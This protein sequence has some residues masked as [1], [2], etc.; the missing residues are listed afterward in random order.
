MPHAIMKLDN[1]VFFVEYSGDVYD[2]LLIEGIYL[3]NSQV[4]LVEYMSDAILSKAQ[5]E[6]YQDYF[7]LLACK[8]EYLREM[9]LEMREAARSD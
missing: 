6:V 4:N 7:D 2:Y 1:N 9:Q 3:Q 5:D 8:D